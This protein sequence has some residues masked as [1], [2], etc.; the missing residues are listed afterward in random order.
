MKAI[1]YHKY[2]A[3]DVLQLEELEKPSPRANEVLIRVR[4]AT[5]S[6]AEIVAR[7]GTRSWQ[8]LLLA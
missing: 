7:K 4:A 5:V 2:G 3:P 8:G 1:V 6:A